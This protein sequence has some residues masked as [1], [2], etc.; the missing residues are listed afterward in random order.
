MTGTSVQPLIPSTNQTRTENRDPSPDAVVERTFSAESEEPWDQRRVVDQT[1][2]AASKNTATSASKKIQAMR[3][4]LGNFEEEVFEDGDLPSLTTRQGGAKDRV[5]GRVVN[6]QRTTTRP[7]SPPSRAGMVEIPTEQTHKNRQFWGQ[8]EDDMEDRESSRYSPVPHDESPKR[9]REGRRVIRDGKTGR[10]RGEYNDDESAGT[11]TLAAE[12]YDHPETTFCGQALDAIGDM[13]GVDLALAADATGKIKDSPERPA[14]RR[15]TSPAVVAQDQ[16]QEQTAIEVEFVEPNTNL[17]PERKNAYLTA[18]AKRAKKD[19]ESKRETIESDQSSAKPGLDAPASADVYNGFSASEKRKFLKLINSGL[20]PAVA[21]DEVCRDRKQQKTEKKSPRGASRLAF[22]KKGPLSPQSRDRSASSG[23]VQTLQPQASSGQPHHSSGI[24]DTSASEGLKIIKSESDSF[25]EEDSPL[26][27]EQ[28]AGDAPFALKKDD[29]V[30]DTTHAE[31]D[32]SD[33]EAGQFTR[34]GINYY[35]AVR[36]DQ[37]DEEGKGDDF[38]SV[39]SKSVSRSGSKT[40]TK[41]MTRGF[42]KLDAKRSRSAPRIRVPDADSISPPRARGEKDVESAVAGTLAVVGLTDAESEG[43]KDEKEPFARKTVESLSADIVSIDPST[44]DDVDSFDRIEKNLLRPVPK[45]DRGKDFVGRTT[46]ETT[47]SEIR[48]GGAAHRRSRSEP[49]SSLRTQ[50]KHT[51]DGVDV[52]AM[53]I[54]MHTYFSSTDV[55]SLNGNNDSGSLYTSGT[56]LTSASSYTQSSRVRRPGAA[57]GRLAQTKRVK[58]SSS[59]NGWAESIRA[60]AASSNRVWHPAHGWVDF[61]DREIGSVEADTSNEKIHLNLDHSLRHSRVP[62]EN[63]GSAL[64]SEA[65]DVGLSSS[66]EKERSKILASGSK[67]VPRHQ[68]RQVQGAN[69]QD[70]GTS[71]SSSPSTQPRGWIESMRAASASV[72]EDTWDPETGWRNVSQDQVGNDGDQDDWQPTGDHASEH[73]DKKLNQWI[74]KVQQEPRSERSTE[75]SARAVA[76]GVVGDAKYMQLGDNGSVRSFAKGN[77]PTLNDLKPSDTIPPVE[78]PQMIAAGATYPSDLDNDDDDSPLLKASSSFPS[79]GLDGGNPVPTRVSSVDVVKEKVGQDEFD[80]FHH[81]DSKGGRRQHDTRPVAST[82]VSSSTTRGRGSG[83]VD[84][85]EVDVTSDD[86]GSVEVERSAGPH[87]DTSSFLDI[88][89]TSSTQSKTVPRLRRSKRDTSPIRDRK[90]GGFGVTPTD[91][92]KA[93]AAPIT[94]DDQYRSEGS[95]SPSREATH[96]KEK[97]P[98]GKGDNFKQDNQEAR[99]DFSGSNVSSIKER[100]QQWEHRSAKPVGSSDAAEVTPEWKAFL[101]KKVRAESNAAAK[102]EL[103]MRRVM[104][105]EEMNV[106]HGERVVRTTRQERAAAINTLDKEDDDTLFDFPGRG[107][108]RTQHHDDSGAASGAAS[109]LDTSD[110]SPVDQKGSFEYEASEAYGPDPSDGRTFFQR[111]TECAAPVMAAST[112]P[113][114]GPVISSGAQSNEDT[115]PMAHLAFLRSSSQAGS[116]PVTSKFIPPALCGRMGMVQDDADSQISVEAWAEG[117][118]LSKAKRGADEGNSGQRSRSVS[119]GRSRSHSRSRGKSNGMG[120]AASVVSD[121]GFGAKTA[122]LDAIAMRAAVSKPRRSDSRRRSGRSSASVTSNA[123][124]SQ[125]S[126]SEQ[127]KSFLERKKAREASPSRSRP[128][129]SLGIAAEKYASEKVEEMMESLAAHSRSAPKRASSSDARLTSMSLR[130]NDSRTP[131]DVKP[132]TESVRAAEDLAAA[133]VEAMMSALAFSNSR[134]EEE[135]E[136]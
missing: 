12:S 29:S 57:K 120:S 99:S 117:G 72:T 38:R 18:M 19:F 25:E 79:F 126:H 81:D 15:P 48:S 82:E 44:G 70:A 8:F 123:S 125:N 77:K 85:D 71:T 46:P 129:S 6:G 124:S 37:S 118:E 88:S 78:S 132:K 58:A 135:G 136:I 14:I 121:D 10:Q 104:K 7:L 32:S 31:S 107:S 127:W 66:M 53:E 13:C 23:K 47:H 22:W 55:Y 74:A 91:V 3:N 128:G 119:A 27:G 89:A 50:Q 65:A 111:L 63:Q 101:G 4:E 131:E 134:R 43:H 80:L 92:T 76:S 61:K 30:V 33:G 5:G 21:A 73:G 9:G 34:S 87:V 83:P 113:C 51:G 130:I 62:N 16:V 108:Q 116:K 90:A 1:S 97:V 69:Y 95:E 64:T 122:Y 11:R 115:V 102:Q 60:V 54:S 84:I 56:N 24:E 17:S 103:S 41:L 105:H 45:V 35:D 96:T 109:A 75:S 93:P 94:P 86:D 112:A 68:E 110:L 20:S 59:Q 106:A 2:G 28:P 133:R 49:D 36:K 67:V 42:A 52:D 98:V 39:S 114:T 40:V 26:E 100:L